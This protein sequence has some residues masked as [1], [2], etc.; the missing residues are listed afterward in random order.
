[1]I[2]SLPACRFE[3]DWTY[4]GLRCLQLE[5][6]Y[7]KLLV[8]PQLGGHIARLIDKRRDCNVLWESPRVRLHRTELHS[9]FDDHWSGG[10]D[11]M[12]PNGIAMR[13]AAGDAL[14]AMGEL[15]NAECDW[16]VVE[17]SDRR[18]EVLLR[19]KTP[20]SPV[21]VERRYEVTFDRPTVEVSYRLTNLGTSAIPY[22]FG[23]HPSLEVTPSHRLDIPARDA[24]VS[25]ET[26]GG[27]LGSPGEAY[28]WPI[29]NGVDLSRPL[30]LASQTYALH[31]LKDLEA[32]W[33]AN[34]CTTER[35]GVGFVFDP[36]T[37]PVLGLWMV[38]GGWR[39]YYHANIEPF[40]GYPTD[41]AEAERA[42]RARYLQAGSS[43]EMKMTALLY[44][45]LDAVASLSRDGSAVGP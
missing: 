27:D 42:G 13:T 20:I 5:N 29:L 23:V 24:E 3:G 41:L 8:F 4:R 34:T 7:L 19:M 40:T 37:F 30:P 26:G 11:D 39:G 22:I 6:N 16:Q 1:M 33:A 12:F 32:G 45:G 15:W 36:D 10:W 35:A 21:E 18:V 28:R 9:N 14:P 2:S 25:E 31:Y 44:W 38:Y 43:V 17:A